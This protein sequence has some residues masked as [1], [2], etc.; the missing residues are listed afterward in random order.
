MF[1]D[2]Q[3][4]YNYV[5]ACKEY[6][7]DAPIIPGLKPITNKRQLTMI[8]SFFNVDI[9]VDL[10]RAMQAAKTDAACEQIGTEWLLMQCRDLLKNNVPIL[11]FYTLGK[12]N[13]VINVL[14]QLF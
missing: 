2:N 6:K 4:Y 8:P 13:V 9:P 1:F 10:S 7:I 12:P 14:K 11:H 3:H 5:A